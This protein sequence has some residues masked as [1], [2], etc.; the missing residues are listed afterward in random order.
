MEKSSG[1][2][3][4]ELFDSLKII[5]DSLNFLKEGKEHQIIPL[6]GQIRAI[7]F[8]N[9]DSN[10]KNKTPLILE[11]AQNIKYDTDIYLLE[12]K[13]KITTRGLVFS[14]EKPI[15]SLEY[16]NKDYKKIK[17]QDYIKTKICKIG[18]EDKTI[19]QIIKVFANK[20]GG[21]H[22][23]PKV[24]KFLYEL[25]LFKIGEKSL[26]TCIIQDLGEI[27][28]KICLR[29]LRKK[30]EFEFQILFGLNENM[31]K[32]SKNII[33]YKYGNNNMGLSLRAGLANKL[34]IMLR[35]IREEEI[36]LE[37]EIDLK[38]PI[39]LSIHYEIKDSLNTKLVIALNENILYEKEENKTIFIYNQFDISN[40]EFGDDNLKL[41]ISKI[42]IYCNYLS[43]EEKIQNLEYIKSLLKEKNISGKYY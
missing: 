42:M 40:V 34:E 29:M 18:G 3:F 27:L 21:A 20:N 12:R 6:S 7:L 26:V 8:D 11:V 25:S 13:E 28:H 19:E 5:N 35:G 31:S 22:Y 37:I 38:K 2:K 32:E 17:L 24:P 4:L 39:F 9:K 16:I 33:T 36:N 10:K 41:F 14:Y 1:T 23:D 15:I 43:I 30:T